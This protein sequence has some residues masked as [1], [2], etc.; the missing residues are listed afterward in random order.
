VHSSKLRWNFL[1]H[2]I[3]NEG[4]QVNESKIATMKNWP[5]PDNV[6]KL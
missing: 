5:R 4:V 2:F 6:T 1:G 3:S